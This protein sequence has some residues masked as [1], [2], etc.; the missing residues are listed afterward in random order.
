LRVTRRAAIP[1]EPVRRAARNRDFSDE[2][3][4]R[5]R[6]GQTLTGHT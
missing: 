1:T 5:S 4:K 6:M 3:S 2:K